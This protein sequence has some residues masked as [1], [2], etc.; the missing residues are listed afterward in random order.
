MHASFMR[1]LES[2]VHETVSSC[3]HYAY[4]TCG[5]EFVLEGD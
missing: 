3:S 5:P 2:Y 1:N 4:L